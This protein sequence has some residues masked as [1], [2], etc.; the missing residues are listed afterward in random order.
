[1]IKNNR[2]YLSVQREVARL[3][4]LDDFKYVDELRV[5]EHQV[6]NYL[7]LTV[8]EVSSFTVT[9]FEDIPEVLIS[10]RIARKW[11]QQD[12]AEKLGMK[13][14]Q[15]QRYE[16]LDYSTASFNTLIKV[17]KVLGVK[18]KVSEFELVELPLLT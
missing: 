17:A 11:T 15:I 16:Q 8:G 13:K 1:M 12:L 14:Q 10:A 4:A 18:L 3:R 9:E 2:Q 5:L 6:L 7:K